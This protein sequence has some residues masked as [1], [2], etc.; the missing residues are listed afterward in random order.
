MKQRDMVYQEDQ[1]NVT[2]NQPDD[3]RKIEKK[4]GSLGRKDALGNLQM[5]QPAS[6]NDPILEVLYISLPNPQYSRHLWWACYLSTVV[7]AE[8]LTFETIE[9]CTGLVAA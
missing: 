6:G 2:S 5:I 4:N 1:I 8:I 3:K 7:V 9:L